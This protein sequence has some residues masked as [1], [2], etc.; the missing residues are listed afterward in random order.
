MP[1]KKVTKKPAPKTKSGGKKG[2][3]KSTKKTVPKK[4]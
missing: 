2:N 4:K 1:S 3:T